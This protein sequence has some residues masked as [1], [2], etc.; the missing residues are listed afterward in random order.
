MERP[1]DSDNKDINYESK[2]NLGCLTGGTSVA[3]IEDVEKDKPVL[4]QKFKQKEEAEFLN[5]GELGGSPLASPEQ[6]CSG[7][8]NIPF[9]QSC[10]TSK[11]W[12]F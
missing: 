10:G 4:A 3:R 6:W 8:L 7:S 1:S 5:L 9:D 12:D 11:W 2:E